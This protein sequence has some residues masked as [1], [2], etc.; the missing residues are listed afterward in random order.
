[1]NSKK[2]MQRRILIKQTLTNIRK[3][4]DNL[5]GQ[6]ERYIELAKQAKLKGATSQYNLALSG[7][8]ACMIQIKKAE[9][10]ALNIEIA[11]QMRDL[12]QMQSTFLNVMQT[13]SKDMVKTTKSMDFAKV[14]SQFETAMAQVESTTDQLD[15]MLDSSNASYNAMFSGNGKEDLESLINTESA[16]SEDGLDAEIDA[17]INEIKRT[18]EKN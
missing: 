18:L 9:E 15:V 5:T 13:I 3:Y 6:Q 8:K 7:L 11:S 17:K 14:T 4:V 2:D 10:M 12:T 1:M 16:G